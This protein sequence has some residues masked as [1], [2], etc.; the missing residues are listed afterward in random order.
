[1]KAAHQNKCKRVVITSSVAS[2]M[3]TRPHEDKSH[4]TEEDWSDIPSCSPYEKSKTMAE[5]AA[6]DFLNDLP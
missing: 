5:K 3:V 2:V 4:F 1:M 6:W